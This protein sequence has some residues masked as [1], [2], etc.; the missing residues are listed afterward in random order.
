M[1]N[2]LKDMGIPMPWED[3][4]P[5]IPNIKPSPNYNVGDILINRYKVKSILDKGGMGD[6]YHCLDIRRSTDVALKTIISS[7]KEDHSKMISFSHEV[8]RLLLLPPHPNILTL[9]RIESI[10]GY[11]FIVSEWVSSENGTTLADWKKQRTFTSAEVLNFMQQIACG[12]SHCRKYLSQQNQP[13]VYSDIKPDNIFVTWNCIYKLGDFSGGYNENW[14][15]PEFQNHMRYDERADIYSLGKVATFM[16]SPVADLGSE[17][18]ISLD[19]II[20]RCSAYDVEDRFP[21][22]EALQLELSELCLRL[23]LKSYDDKERFIRPFLDDYNRVVSA[24]NIG[25]VPSLKGMKN[26]Y[27]SLVNDWHGS[28]YKSINDFQETISSEEKRLFNAKLH[29]LSGDFDKTLDDLKGELLIP[30][31]LH[32][33]A[34]V[35][36]N[37]GEITNSF[38]CLISSVLLEDHLPSFD[39]LATILLNNPNLAFQCRQEI[40]VLDERLDKLPEK[41]FTGY[42]PYQ[43]RAKFFMLTKNYKMACSYFRKCLQYP[44]PESDW[45]VLYY[46]GSCEAMAGNNYNSTYIMNRTVNLILSDPNH[47]QNSYKTC[48][49]FYCFV[50]LK[51]V[52]KAEELADYLRTAFNFDLSSYI[53]NLRRETSSD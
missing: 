26:D 50:S 53:E 39:L 20:Q 8:N 46:Y 10:D 36:Y 22:I 15:A 21:T 43:V 16:L 1:G 32:L 37:K 11:F 17:L 14:C 52:E 35:F 38:Q 2:I 33:K 5:I 19:D 25:Y 48:V 29:Y 7:D 34:V 3:G 13:Y 47:L 28:L 23:D 12:L 41:R 51:C 40:A 24:L 6:V 27:E 44:N 45:Q 4:L 49:L 18:F 42:L 9:Q 30:D 31:L